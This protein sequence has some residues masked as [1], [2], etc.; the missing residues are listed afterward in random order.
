MAASESRSREPGA[1]L[2]AKRPDTAFSGFVSGCRTIAF[3]L[4]AAIFL[5]TSRA[6]ARDGAAQAREILREDVRTT[7][8][9]VADAMNVRLDPAEPLPVVHLAS[10][11]TLARFR[12]AIA[13]QWGFRPH[14]IVNAYAV[15]TNEI[16]LDDAPAY[17]RRTHRTLDDSLAHELAHYLQVRYRRLDLTDESCE[18]EA[19]T[20][21]TAYREHLALI[22]PVARGA[23]HDRYRSS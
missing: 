20:I 18:M 14:V 10:T 2:S 17:Y 15:A 11:T 12:E 6:D 21:Q 3:A 8:A 1:V 23:R 7:L 16:Y 4:F 19:V 5:M 13:P 9:F 22:A